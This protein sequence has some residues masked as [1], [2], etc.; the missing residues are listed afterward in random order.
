MRNVS[1]KRCRKNQST[2]FV[3]SII[4]PPRKSCSLWIMW[5][6]TVEPS[7][8]QMIMWRMSIVCRI[9]KTSH[10]LTISNTYWFSTATMVART[11]FN[12]T[13]IRTLPVL[14]IFTINEPQKEWDVESWKLRVLQ[15][16]LLFTVFGRKYLQCGYSPKF[17]QECREMDM[18]SRALSSE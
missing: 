9:T 17:P 11:L 1:D 4:P 14:F 10:T 16:P 5:Q 6:N 7:R 3:F 15:H 2:H 12:V 18:L 13:L 8:H